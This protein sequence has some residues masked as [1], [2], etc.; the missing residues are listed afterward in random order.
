MEWTESMISVRV[1]SANVEEH[2]KEGSTE[3]ENK[4]DSLTA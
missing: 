4:I 3:L 1:K 2:R